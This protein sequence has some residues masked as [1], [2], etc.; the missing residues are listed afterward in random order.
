MTKNKN[1]KR[2]AALRN[3]TTKIAQMQV[4]P[5]KKKN[6][7]KKK[8]MS[9]MGP[10]ASISTA[11]VAIGNS[12]K[13]A[14]AV[15]RNTPNGCVVRG[16]DFMFTPIG[17]NTITTWCMVGGT[18]LSPVAFGDSVVREYMQMYQK[19][20]WRSCTVYYITSSPTSSTGDVMFYYSKNRDSVFLNQTSS[21]LLPFV[22]S[23]PNTVLGPQWTNHAAK[24]EI[25]PIWKSTDYGM[26][27]DP[28]QYAAG[29]V[30]LLSKT[31]TTD[32]PGYVL[33]DY[34]IEFAEIQI[35]P[36]LLALPLPR[37]QYTNIALTTSGAKTAGGI[38]DFISGGGT[39]LSGASGANPNGFLA[40]DIYKVI[41]DST[42]SVYT[43]GTAANLL[44]VSLGNSNT[45]NLVISDGLTVYG[46]ADQGGAIGLYQTSTDAYTASN[47]IQSQTNQTP[48]VNIQV[49]VSLLGSM[50]TLGLKPNY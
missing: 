36:R 50:S 15:S 40:G 46:V 17:T 24:L 35:S 37:A 3:L 41:F 20:R 42:N 25:E 6:K 9:P 22:I 47:P 30:F 16:R 49:W 8:A 2:A 7:K 13:G 39:L 4:T 14:K 38:M 28:N 48:N 34:E 43:T 18:P 27:A 23:D 21:F 45:Y 31:T 44:Q 32:S 5:K 10:V 19:F 26:A 11:P 33:F 12:I 29:E 1:K